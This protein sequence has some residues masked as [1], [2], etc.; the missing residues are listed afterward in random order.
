[1]SAD[2][3]LVRYERRGKVALITLDRPPVNALSMAMYRAIAARLDQLAADE[4]VHVGV[5]TGAGRRAFCAGADIHELS[6]LDSTTRRE[7]HEFVNGVWQKL[8]EAALP[9]VCAIGGAAPGG[10][11]VIGSLCDYRIASDDSVFSYPEID[12][13]TVGG[14]GVFLTRTGVP[15]GPT[16]DILYSGRK[17]SAEQ[18]L[19]LRLVDRVVPYDQLLPAALALAD[20]WATKSRQALILMKRAIRAAE[21]ET[22]WLS[23]Y[24]A[25]HAISAEFTGTAAAQEGLRSFREKRAPKYES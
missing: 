23:G 22:D 10:G 9:L 20:E 19:A 18:A 24:R 11:A 21:A 12:R 7:R 3:N 4:S 14:G 2:T 8:G 15:P 25:T 5:I 13:G 1:M 6:T 17:M 16:R